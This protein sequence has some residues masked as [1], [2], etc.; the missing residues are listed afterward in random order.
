MEDAV[1]NYYTARL[2]VQA[3]APQESGE[4]SSNSGF[5]SHEEIGQFVVR[6]DKR[7]GEILIE[8]GLESDKVSRVFSEPGQYRGIV[9]SEL[10]ADRLDFL[11]RTSLH[12]GLPYGSIDLPY[13]L[14]NLVNEPDKCPCLSE[15]AVR[16]AEHFLLCRLFDRQQ[17]AYHKSVA[18]FELVL[19]EA[20]AILLQ[21]EKLD[22]S[23]KAVDELIESGDWAYFDDATVSSKVL[24]VHKETGDDFT[25]DVMSAL[26]ER[27][28]PKLVFSYDDIAEDETKFNLFKRL[29]DSDRAKWAKQVGVDAQRLLVWSQK[30][31]PIT[32]G[33]PANPE[34]PEESVWVRRRNGNVTRL[35]DVRGSIVNALNKAKLCSIRVYF[36]SSNSA[37]VARLK[38]IIDRDTED[39]RR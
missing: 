8:A 16:A 1:K 24:E 28:S 21:L 19:K 6:R 2:A 35:V 11:P 36:L 37:Q 17:V 7:I 25:K 12:T 10:D 13:L 30:P 4:Q 3:T 20:I 14:S 39:C 18:G 5:Y 23:A 38:E 33:A 9:K 26:V 27:K 15:K 34:D 32:K 31:K 22:C 29:V